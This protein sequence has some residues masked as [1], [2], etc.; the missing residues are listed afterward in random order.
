[1]DTYSEQERA[2][3]VLRI[4]EQRFASFH[5]IHYPESGTNLSPQWIARKDAAG[6]DERTMIATKHY[7][8]HVNVFRKLNRNRRGGLWR[9]GFHPTVQARDLKGR[10][11][12]ILLSDV[13][14][15]HEHGNARTPARP[16]WRP[17]LNRMRREA[18]AV[19]REMKDEI[20]KAM[21]AAVGKRLVVK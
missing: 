18:P 5:V 4:K 15:I 13:A 17:N 10:V 2:E 19:R 3:F 6:A 14:A 9:I 20:A 16:H 8:R 12:P 11:V 7:I 1:M 21:R